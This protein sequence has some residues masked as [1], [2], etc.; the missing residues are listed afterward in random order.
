MTFVDVGANIG[1]HTLLAA[2][3]VQES[4]LV[5]SFEPTPRT[6]EI[7]RTNVVVNGYSGRVRIHELALTDKRGAAKLWIGDVCGH[8]TL[9]GKERDPR[10]SIEVET[11][12]LDEVLAG[13]P[14]IDFVKVDAEGAEPFILRGMRQILSRCPR[15]Q[16]AV[17]F[18]PVWLE[19]AG[20]HPSDFLD[21]I[22]GMGFSI[23]R[24]DDIT[25]E[26]A[27]VS[28]DTMLHTESMNLHLRPMAT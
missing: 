2:S 13:V 25:G 28:L 6:C 3:R 12:S 1:I 26:T 7:L 11:L 21:E 22:H 19:A 5:H 14:S 24:I 23:E 15:L 27:P 9:F 18:A 8:N 16:L 20:L 10:R 4:G 17:E